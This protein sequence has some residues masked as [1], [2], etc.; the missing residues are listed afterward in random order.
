MNF[1]IGDRI[2]ASTCRRSMEREQKFEKQLKQYR[3][4]QIRGYP[5]AP[6]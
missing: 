3:W 5:D 1:D 2:E 6:N 4:W